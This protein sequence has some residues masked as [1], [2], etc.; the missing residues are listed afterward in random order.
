MPTRPGKLERITNLVLALLDTSRPLP[1]RE[2]G[3][4]VAGYPREPAALRQA[5]ER[6]KRAL[7]D[8]GIPVSTERIEGSDQYGY[9]ILPEQYYLADLELSA[10]EEQALAF[11]LTAVR[12]EGGLGRS[13]GTKLGLA[14]RSDP[15]PL[16]LLPALPALGPLHQAVR[17]RAV[18]TFDYHR[19]RRLV[20]PYGLVFRSG[21][22]Y[23]V[24]F[25]RTAGRSGGLRTFRVDRLESPP[26]PGESAGF[27]RPAG[28]DVAAEVRLA[29]ARAAGA[30]LSPD[31][32]AA[33]DAARVL[34]EFSAAEAAAALG[35]VGSGALL[36]RRLD[37]SVLLGCDVADEDAFARWVAGFGQ[38]ALVLG[39]SSLR[40]RVVQILE[41][42]S[43]SSPGEVPPA[44]SERRQGRRSRLGGDCSGTL[45]GG[46]G[47]ATR[48]G[49]A[50]LPGRDG[51]QKSPQLDAGT[52]LR[53][54]LALLGH[55]AR[56]GEASLDE[57][58]ERFD[59]PPEVLVAELELAACC[60]LPPYTPDQLL[61]LVVDGERVVAFGLEP[62]G[63]RPQLTA[64][65]GFAV[66]AAARAMLR[67][68]GADAAGPLAGALVKLEATLG[69]A[70]M[71]EVEIDSPPM[72]E[73]LRHAAARGEAVEIDY[74][75]RSGD[76][77]ARTVE[78]HVVI[79]REGRWYLDAWSE[80]AGGWRRF[81]LDRVRAV[82]PLG[83]PVSERALPAAFTRAQA[84]VGGAGTA[85]ALVEVPSG[86]RRALERV[87][88]GPAQPGGTASSIVMPVDVADRRWFGRLLLGVPS[89]VV[90]EPRSLASARRDEAAAALA[91]YRAPVP[92]AVEDPGTR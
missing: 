2:I 15:V 44:P 92:A 25:D 89:A 71:L 52:R 78:P 69:D 9:R 80:T 3:D 55:L 17:E 32:G 38:G 73:P 33:E 63:R 86:E 36:E 53:R 49:G 10:E 20:E 7:R 67:V 57:L 64:E 41:A 23:L 82:R 24:G 51:G 79:V 50:E 47:G 65:E 19:R 90:L 37:G 54:L 26:Q 6:D 1:L 87:A 85:R 46:A 34:V 70:G 11:A 27:D 91:R 28:L 60:G 48:V 30:G 56:V 13:V 75:D 43:A 62:L 35:A 81:Q 16:A 12:L 84:F 72:L 22:W 74:V 83:R 18:V 61:E 58:A 4:T 29:P 76:E 42:A 45:P 14:A 68:P 88:A 66:A 31:G 8:G 77:H 5:F 40:A 39:P 59:L 21:S